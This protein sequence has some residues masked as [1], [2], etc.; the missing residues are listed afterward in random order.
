MAHPPMLPTTCSTVF[1]L[2]LGLLTEPVV[3]QPQWMNTDLSAAARTELLLDA[4]TL[5]QKIQQMQTIPSPNEE[6]EGCG[7]QRLGRHVEG[8]PELDS[9][10]AGHQRR[11][12]DAGR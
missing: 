12:R 6:L 4:M 1:A 7:F 3:A 5:D 8:I 10:A 2:A 9:D 11:Q